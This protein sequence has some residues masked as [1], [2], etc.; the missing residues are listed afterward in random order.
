MVLAF[1]EC[2]ENSFVSGADSHND[3]LF[4]LVACYLTDKLTLTDNGTDGAFLNQLVGENHVE[5]D[6][7]SFLTFSGNDA[8]L[9]L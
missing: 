4:N 9:G 3:S 7:G 1:L 5:T 2:C 6:Y 8:V